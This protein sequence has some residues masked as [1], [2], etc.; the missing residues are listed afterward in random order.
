MLLE[1]HNVV[2]IFAYLGSA[3]Q[4]CQNVNRL[5]QNSVLDYCHL[6]FERVDFD[7]KLFN[8]TAALLQSK[9]GLLWAGGA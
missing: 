4:F 3:G 8:D 1:T 7:S 6:L 5:T 9:L 2:R